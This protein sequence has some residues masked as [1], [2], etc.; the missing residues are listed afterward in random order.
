MLSILPAQHMAILTS[1]SLPYLQP[2]P[3]QTGSLIDTCDAKECEHGQ[4]CMW[5][6]GL[7]QR[8]TRKHMQS[9]VS[10]LRLATHML[11]VQLSRPID[12]TG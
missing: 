2:S 10:C 8:V 12:T 9:L 3:L 5:G 7:E 1:L 4:L 11:K 6:W